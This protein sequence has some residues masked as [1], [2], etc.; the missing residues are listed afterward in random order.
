MHPEAMTILFMIMSSLASIDVEQLA[1][2]RPSQHTPKIPTFQDASMRHF[3]GRCKVSAL[4]LCH[5]RHRR[6]D[7]GDQDIPWNAERDVMDKG[8]GVTIDVVMPVY[9]KRG[10]MWRG[11]RELEFVHP[12]TSC[13]MECA[14]IHLIRIRV[15]Y[16][17]V[18]PVDLTVSPEDQSVL[19]TNGE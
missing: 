6:N 10:W 2:L 7:G 1:V 16:G 5:G 4:I 17:H 18:H 14:Q 15:E 11:G 13:S 3:T 12:Y 8:P 9:G 19:I